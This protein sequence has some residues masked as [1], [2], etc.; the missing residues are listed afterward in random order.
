MIFDTLLSGVPSGNQEVDDLAKQRLERASHHRLFNR[1]L[2]PLA[3][4]L[5]A[6]ASIIAAARSSPLWLLTLLSLPVTVLMSPTGFLTNDPLP[7]LRR[8]EQ[9]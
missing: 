3:V 4:T 5:V 1:L 6:A 2:P 8:F 9:G 7:R